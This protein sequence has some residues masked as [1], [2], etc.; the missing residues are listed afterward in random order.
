MATRTAGKYE[1]SAQAKARSH[2]MWFDQH[3]DSKYTNAEGVR[4]FEYG[5]PWWSVIEKASGMPTG[6]VYPL[7][8]MAPF[9]PPPSYINDSIGR[10]PKQEFGEGIRP[11]ETQSDRFRIDYLRMMQDDREATLTHYQ[12]AVQVASQKNLPIPRMGEVMDHRLIAIVGIQPRS[13][14]IAE[15]CLAG[16]KWLLGQQM[17]TPNP[18]TGRMEVEEDEELARLLKIASPSVWT[19]EQAERAADA[20]A[21]VS[22]ELKEMLAEALAMKQELAKLKAEMAA[23]PKKRGRPRKAEPVGTE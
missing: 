21:Q 8:W 13:P 16:N 18:L 7:G 1:D 23:A 2:A 17:P 4:I 19:A 11:M 12:Y 22:S 20:T 9:L 15:A 14:K 10:I 5:R 3:R 6:P